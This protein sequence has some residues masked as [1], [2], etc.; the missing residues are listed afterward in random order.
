MVIINVPVCQEKYFL[1]RDIMMSDVDVL[2]L[3]KEVTT[4][5]SRKGIK[6]KKKF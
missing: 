3:W 4:L 5:F 2:L 6:G 1:K